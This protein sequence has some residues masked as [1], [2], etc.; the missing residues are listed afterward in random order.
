MLL[1]QPNFG[2]LP[3]SPTDESPDNDG[4][5]PLPPSPLH[6]AQQPLQQQE[7]HIR[8]DSYLEH[9][10]MRSRLKGG[11]NTDSYHRDSSNPPTV[12]P[13]RPVP[14]LNTLK[15]RSMDAGFS[16]AYRSPSFN[17]TTSGSV[18]GG[19]GHHP[20]TLPP[21]FNPGM[22]S[23]RRLVSGAFPKKTMPSPREERRLHTSCSLPETPIFARGCDIPRTP[24]RRAP[25]LPPSIGS[26]TA[27]RT[28]NSMN[29]SSIMGIG[30]GQRV[31]Y[32]LTHNFG[33]NPQNH[34]ASGSGH[35]PSTNPRC[36]FVGGGN[37]L[38]NTVRSNSSGGSGN[39]RLMLQHHQALLNGEMLRLAGGPARGWYPKQR[40][41]TRPVSTEHLDRLS[42]S[43]GSAPGGGMSFRGTAWADNAAGTAGR[44]PCTLP[45]NL[46]PKFFS[47]KSSPRE[48]IRRVTSLLIR[49]GIQ[50]ERGGLQRSE[51]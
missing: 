28:T 5:P 43:V 39:T 38:D 34:L 3:P 35:K 12:P 29:N 22:N 49:K 8:G 31:S 26:R 36:A 48:A 15:T 30:E 1:S 42:S 14:S 24:H 20:G 27:P 41:T 7:V 16:K 46:T 10:R 47:S 21:E 9:H 4:F 45:P 33:I 51:E 19:G 25:E 37:T 13:H 6:E 44:K 23:R 17:S 32:N 18:G 11:A 40:Q 50:G 2:P